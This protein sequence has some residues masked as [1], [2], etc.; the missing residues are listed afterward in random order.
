MSTIHSNIKSI[1]RQMERVKLLHQMRKV[2]HDAAKD[3][4]RRLEVE[5]MDRVKQLPEHE[6]QIYLIKKEFGKEF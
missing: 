5:L 6:K 3:E 4:L 1:E 2:T